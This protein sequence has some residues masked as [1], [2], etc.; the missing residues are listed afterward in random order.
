MKA[1][2]GSTPPSRGVQAGAPDIGLRRMR[3]ITLAG[4]L[5]PDLSSDG[6]VEPQAALAAAFGFGLNPIRWQIANTRAARF[7]V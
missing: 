2:K 6:K 5:T 1:R 7:I 4:A 3:Q